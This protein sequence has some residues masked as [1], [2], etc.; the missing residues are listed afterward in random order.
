MAKMILVVIGSV[1]RQ[2]DILWRFDPVLIGVS[3]K[4]SDGPGIIDSVIKLIHDLFNQDDLRGEPLF[5]AV[6]GQGC[7]S[8][9]KFRGCN[10]DD[11]RPC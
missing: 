2:D 10:D 11:S 8:S 4:A 7:G 3:E 6:V 9:F 5:L 1:P